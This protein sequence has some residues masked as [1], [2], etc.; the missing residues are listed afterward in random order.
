MANILERQPLRELN[1]WKVGGEAEFFA[2]PR[3][4][5]EL[6]EAYVWAGARGL[7]VHVLSAGSNVLLP[8]GVLKG[9]VISVHALVGVEKIETVDGHVQIVALAGTP[10]SDLAKYFLQNKLAPAIFLTGIPGDVGAGVVMNAGIGESR[11]PREFCEIVSEVEVLRPPVEGRCDL[12]RVPAS[13]IRWEYRR[14]T[15]WQPGIIVRVVVR[16]PAV[17][18]VEVMTAVREQTRKRVSTQ[19][20]DLPNCGSVFRNPLGHKA[21]QLIQGAGLKGFR[22]GGAAVSTK[23]ANFIVNDQGATSADIL[24]VIDHVRSE[25][26]KQ[27]GVQLETEVV[28]LGVESGH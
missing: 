20:L 26:F 10:K 5:D 22:V 19:P 9:L 12:V 4:I 21:A 2:L 23:H 28:R 8:D 15:G 17:A 13:Q 6:R 11:T 14:S 25:V 7:P 3:T 24:A 1:W 16:W 18:D 27:S